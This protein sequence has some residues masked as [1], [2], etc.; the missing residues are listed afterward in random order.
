[1]NGLDLR[2]TLHD[3]FKNNDWPIDDLKRRIDQWTDMYLKGSIEDLQFAVKAYDDGLTS[4]KAKYTPRPADLKEKYRIVVERR[5]MKEQAAHREAERGV[6]RKTAAFNPEEWAP[7]AGVAISKA[8]DIVKMRAH[9]VCKL[10]CGFRGYSNKG[11]IDV[12]EKD[13]FHGY[14]DR[15]VTIAWPDRDI[16][17]DIEAQALRYVTE[18]LYPK[19][20][21]PM[22]ISSKHKW[23]SPFKIKN[24]L[25][26]TR[27]VFK[28][29]EDVVPPFVEELEDEPI[30]ATTVVIEKRPE[31]QPELKPEPKGEPDQFGG[32]W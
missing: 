9:N 24:P 7:P 25:R 2:E 32:L 31:P 27:P 13:K 17:M 20:K 8:Q 30:E 18:G 28:Q 3:W 19:A 4:L 26:R 11:I 12:K 5:E 15:L 16:Q 23:E 29:A 6:V 22:D 1:M 21:V 10:W 14:S